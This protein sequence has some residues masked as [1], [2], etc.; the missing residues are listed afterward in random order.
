M[1][2][3]TLSG[4]RPRGSGRK[5]QFVDGFELRGIIQ[6]SRYE[7]G[8]YDRLVVR[9][10]QGERSGMAPQ[11]AVLGGAVLLVLDFQ[12]KRLRVDG[13]RKQEYDK[14]QLSR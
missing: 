5:K 2:G 13:R 6:P 11:A 4:R 10:Y 12:R 3:G 1:V 14:P 9:L 7:N 8:G